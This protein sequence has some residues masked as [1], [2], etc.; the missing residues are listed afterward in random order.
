MR[1]MRKTLR[2]F[3]FFEV[4]LYLGLFSVM[5]TAL[6][7][8]SWNVLDL[9]TKDRTGRQVF[10]DA[11][12]V[13]QRIGYF[14]RNA[15]GIDTGASIFDDADGKLV[16][17]VLGSSDTVT[18]ELQNGDVILTETGQPGVALNGDDTQAESLTFLDYGTEADGSEY[19]DL[20]LVLESAG[21]DT[22]DSPYQAATTLRSGAFIRNSGTGL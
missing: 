14:I 20:T 5:A 18:I 1:K 21:N 2:G 9:G 6:L 19:V 13:T 7:Q 11:R 17:R 22:A 12:F 3:S 4:I 10:S 16:L 8:F 15:S